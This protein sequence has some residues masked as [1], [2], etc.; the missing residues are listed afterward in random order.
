MKN[1]KKNIYYFFRLIPSDFLLFLSGI[2]VA[3]GVNMI[4]SSLPKSII[5]NDGMIILMA[6]LFLI[7]AGF[8]NYWALQINKLNLLAA[9]KIKLLHKKMNE[10]DLW[11]EIFTEPQ[12][13]CIKKSLLRCLLVC[14][15]M[16]GSIILLILF[17][18]DFCHFSWFVKEYQ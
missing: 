11:Y 6:L 9:N 7:M 10:K 18:I 14:I 2:F 5:T 15:I 16:L 4:T 13:H 17:P 3:T 1:I 12:Y 8:L